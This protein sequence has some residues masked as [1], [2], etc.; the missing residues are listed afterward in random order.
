MSN[1]IFSIFV[2]SASDT[3]NTKNPNENRLN[4]VFEKVYQLYWVVRSTRIELKWTFSLPGQNANQVKVVI[5][6][7]VRYC[8]CFFS[9]ALLVRRGVKLNLYERERERWIKIAES[10]RKLL[11]ACFHRSNQSKCLCILCNLFKCICFQLL[12]FAVCKFFIFPS[13]ENEKKRETNLQAIVECWN[14]TSKEKRLS[15]VITVRERWCYIR[16]TVGNIQ[17]NDY[18]YE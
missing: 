17:F 10:C 18:L 8:C 1:G 2:S 15:R 16:H 11:L 13:E 12:C 6:F 14:S 5:F 3:S 9:P 4:R 7:F